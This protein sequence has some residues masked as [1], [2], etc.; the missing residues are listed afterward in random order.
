MS[1][2]L[3]VRDHSQPCEHPGAEKVDIYYWACTQ[4]DCPGGREITLEAHT[5]EYWGGFCESPDLPETPNR[6]YWEFFVYAPFTH[7]VTLDSRIE[8]GG[9]ADV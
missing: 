9:I 7:A 5:G 1:D 2:L 3:T 6:W 4:F 8:V